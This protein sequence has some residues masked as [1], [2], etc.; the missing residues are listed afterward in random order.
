[1]VKLRPISERLA[2][3]ETIMPTKKSCSTCALSLSLAALIALTAIPVREP[4]FGQGTQQQ[5]PAG[6]QAALPGPSDDLIVKL[7]R[8]YK[9]IHANPELSMQERR[10][11]RIAANWLREEGYEVAEGV[12]GTGVVGVLRNGEG[13]T[14]LLRADMD[15]LP[16]EESRASLTRALRPA[17]T[18]RPVGRPRSRTPAGTTCT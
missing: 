15:A 5:S 18:R 11:A 13:A 6:G 10:T 7:E 2:A 17:L 14:V 1:M 3:E 16:M 9:D 12:G 4:A 8:V